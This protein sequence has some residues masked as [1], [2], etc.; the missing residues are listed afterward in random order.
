MEILAEVL[1]IVIDVLLVILL[2]VLI[3]IGIKVIKVM[4]RIKLII[5]DVEGKLASLNGFFSII[6]MVTSKVSVLSDKVVSMAQSLLSKLFN[7]ASKR[8]DGISE[9]DEL[10]E[11]LRDE[12]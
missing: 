8:V 3:I 11:I 12:R 2:T 10:D 1:P 9:E 7:K 4:D 6:D 5:N